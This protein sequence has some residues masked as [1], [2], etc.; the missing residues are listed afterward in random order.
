MLYADS[1]GPAGIRKVTDPALRARRA[2]EALAA[3]LPAQAELRR[4]RD[5]AIREAVAGGASL[6]DLARQLGL[7]KGRI[8]QITQGQ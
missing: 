4:I 5:D 7:T 3:M 1:V 2:E 6:T 8:F